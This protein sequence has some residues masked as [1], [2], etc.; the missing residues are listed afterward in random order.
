MVV[1]WVISFIEE[2]VE[3]GWIASVL[4]GLI[5]SVVVLVWNASIFEPS[6]SAR[7]NDKRCVA[8]Q[9]DLLSAHPRRPDAA[10]LFQALHCR[11]VGEGSVHAP[12]TDRE[13]K[14]G[15][16]LPWGGYPPAR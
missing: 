2:K 16:S 1:F 5:L 11:P 12:P 7:A 14:A 13:R 10:D 9:A 15:R 6:A 4:M 8:V 3:K